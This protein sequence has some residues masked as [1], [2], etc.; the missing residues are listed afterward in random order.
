MRKSDIK[1]MYYNGN[2][3][4]TFYW[5]GNQL[6]KKIEYGDLDFCGVFADDVNDR[7]NT[8]T[9]INISNKTEKIYIPYDAVTKEFK[10]TLTKPYSK[11]T[12]EYPRNFIS[13]NHYPDTSNVT[14]MGYM[15]S[16]CS[17]LTALDVS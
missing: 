8:I 17:S 7:N 3:I 2:E 12:L 14:N 16:E 11:I 10:Y 6:Y 15:F 1:K 4:D 9:I 5:G 13:I